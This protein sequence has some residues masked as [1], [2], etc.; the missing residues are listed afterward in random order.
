MRSLRH[1]GEIDG[2]R[3]AAI[4]LVLL[5]HFTPGH[6]AHLGVRALPFKVADLGW[7]GVDLFFVISGFLITA[8]LIAARGQRHR[9]RNFYVRR[10]LRIFPLYYLALAIAFVLVPLAS[11]RVPAPPVSSQLPF[12]LYYA[13]WLQERFD[14]HYVA[15]GHFWSLAIEEQFYAVWPLVI[16]T[17]SA[18]ASR[19]ACVAIVIAAPLLRFALA[20]NAWPWFPTF[21][22][23]P[24]RADGLAIGSLLAFVYADE[25]LRAR[26]FRWSV[27]LMLATVPP[28]AWVLWRGKSQLVFHDL[29]TPEALAIRTLLPSVLALF[30]GA[31]LVLALELPRLG[32]L[33]STKPLRLLARYSYGTYVFHFLLMPAFLLLF[34]PARL[35]SSPN[36]AAALFWLI[37]SI[38][39]IAIAALSYRLFEGPLLKL[40]D[41]YAKD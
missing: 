8:K 4:L 9:Y 25:R 2:L 16:F 22:W 38:I 18:R 17:L 34:P 41:V 32:R 29:A 33:L 1:F 10:A 11:A 6:D 19:L 37:A 27:A 28:L 30:F 15:V 12:W 31:L 24:C 20:S 26:A 40:K 13:N 7:S 23:T 14:L 5:F 3:A 21:A 36:A 39:S 35:A